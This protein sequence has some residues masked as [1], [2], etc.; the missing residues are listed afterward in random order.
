MT[1]NYMLDPKK[2]NKQKRGIITLYAATGLVALILIYISVKVSNLAEPPWL[3]IIAIPILLIF[4]A[5][6]SIRQR[7]RLWDQYMLTL[8]KGVLTQYEPDG[9][10]HKLALK[11]VVSMKETKEGIF[12]GTNQGPRVFGIPVLLKDEDFEELRSMLTKLLAEKTAAEEE[13]D[14]AEDKE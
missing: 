4:I 2:L 9:A 14:E 1:K 11:D 13:E 7:S 6:R 3:V 12:L 5:I 10:D 8:N